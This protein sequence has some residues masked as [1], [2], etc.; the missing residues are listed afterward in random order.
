MKGPQ[1]R[2][3]SLTSPEGGC[4]RKSYRR[5]YAGGGEKKVGDLR[6][7]CHSACRRELLTVKVGLIISN[8][9]RIRIPEIARRADELGF[10]SLW[11]GE[12]IVLPI[13]NDEEHPYG[14]PNVVQPHNESLAPFV[15]LAFLAGVTE[16]IR[17]ATGVILPPI[18]NLF[19]TA[20]EI[21]TLDVLSGG[22]VDVG[23][24][25]GWHAG[26]FALMGADFAT[27][28]AY[29]DEFIDALQRLFSEERPSFSGRH[30]AFPEVGFEPKPAQ[31]PRPPILVGG[32][33]M[34]A[35][36]RAARRGDGWYGHAASPHQARTRIDAMR[37]VLTEEGRDPADFELVLQVWDPP[38]L[39]ALEAY[40]EAGAERIVT[41]P[42]H[43]QDL[44][45]LTTLETY[46]ERI[47]LSRTA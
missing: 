27:R 25:I 39:E 15:E 6:W 18:R 26:E 11:V 4:N 30:I 41:A 31:K 38:D 5:H 47:G 24:G 9:P 29:T 14:R 22:R 36:R 21:V 28:G 3:A 23:V 20:R 7:V 34:P 10:E 16:R 44:Q 37:E 43:P 33:S 35:M 40:V 32:D 45:P 17:L 2:G 8:A 42:F 1:S 12:H 13:E 46:A 19:A